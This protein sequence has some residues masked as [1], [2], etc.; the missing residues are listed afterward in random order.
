MLSP[1]QLL[2]SEYFP[3]A[4]RGECG[5]FLRAALDSTGG[6]EKIQI[7]VSP[8]YSFNHTPDEVLLL[9]L[10]LLFTGECLLDLEDSDL[11]PGF[12]FALVISF[13]LGTVACFDCF[14]SKDGLLHFSCCFP[15]SLLCS[16]KLN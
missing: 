9:H 14:L 4:T 16:G 13:K 6:D 3:L 7:V 11:A 10:Y 5:T 12:T 1:L 2:T 8:R 15:G